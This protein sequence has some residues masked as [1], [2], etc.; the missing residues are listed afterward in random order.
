MSTN[1]GDFWQIDG[2]KAKIMRS[3]L[4]FHLTEFVSQHY[5]VKR[6]CCKLSHNAESC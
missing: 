4:I 1:L 6:R 2:E 5:H 3:V